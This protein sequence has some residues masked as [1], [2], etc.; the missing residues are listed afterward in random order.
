MKKKM[1]RVDFAA[2]Q[3][4]VSKRTVRNWIDNGILRAQRRG[5]RL[6]FVYAEDVDALSGKALLCSIETAVSSKV[7]RPQK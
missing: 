6:W 7:Y 4:E 1:Y 5:P 3:L 2:E